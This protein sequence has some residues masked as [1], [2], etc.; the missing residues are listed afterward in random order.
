MKSLTIG[1]VANLTGIG[2]ETIR[3]YEKRGLID[4]P[5][6]TESGYRQYPK[7]TVAR[8]RFIRHAKELG[9]TL[10]EIRELMSIRLDPSVRCE[11]VRQ[12]AQGKLADINERIQSLGRMR[13]TL[14]NL[15][16]A[17]SIRSATSECPI[18]EAL[19]PKT[20]Q[21]FT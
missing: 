16:E 10:R 17:C 20:R 6:R 1:K 18:L 14:E 11:D 8:V 15:V 9:F 2:V 5:P 21:H 3:F 4:A 19:E 13:D 7:S 12:I